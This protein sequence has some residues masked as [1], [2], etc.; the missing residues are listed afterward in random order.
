[1]PFDN[2]SYVV[3]TSGLYPLKSRIKIRLKSPYLS[4]L[5]SMQS[6]AAKRFV[7]QCF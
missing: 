6:L 5:E 4:L 1:M 7:V 2:N 3:S